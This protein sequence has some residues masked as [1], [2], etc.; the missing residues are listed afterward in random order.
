MI[1]VN[2]CTSKFLHSRKPNSNEFTSNYLTYFKSAYFKFYLLLDF[3]KFAF[4]T[5]SIKLKKSKFTD[6]QI[7]EYDQ[8]A[9]GC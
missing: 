1:V 9:P 6:I 5:N 3:S 8:S 4:M 7:R 2:K